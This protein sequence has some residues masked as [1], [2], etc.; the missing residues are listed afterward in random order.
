MGSLSPNHS[1][2]GYPSPNL[3]NSI[4]SALK[5]DLEDNKRCLAILTYWCSVDKTENPLFVRKHSENLFLAVFT[6]TEK[7]KKTGTGT[8]QKE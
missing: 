8:T 2:G 6:D 4:E 5:K 1:L 3:G 7:A